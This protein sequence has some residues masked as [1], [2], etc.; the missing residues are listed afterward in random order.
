L[1]DYH[2]TTYDGLDWTP[3][4]RNIIYSGLAG[5]KLQL[6]SIPRVGGTPTQLTHDAGNL[7]QPRVSPD[8]KWI[9]CTRIVQ[10]KQIWRRPL[11]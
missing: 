9:A 2:G 10:S 1:L 5:D 3:D 4:G 8:G 6:F 7:M 11:S